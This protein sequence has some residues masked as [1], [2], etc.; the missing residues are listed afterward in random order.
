VKINITSTISIDESEIRETF[1]RST[2][3]GGQHVN[4][5]STAVQL[6]FDVFRTRSLSPDVRRRLTDI[7]GRRVSGA[8]VLIINA[9]RFRSREQNRK[10][11][12]DRLAVLIRRAAERPRRR[13][14]TRPSPSSRRLRMA[15]KRH[16][17][18]LKRHRGRPGPED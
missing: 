2:G 10:D 14:P 1:V 7:A 17:S 12:L 11:A 15:T 8:G 13:L 9:Q 18:E 16:R 6:R 3:P 4:K 5:V